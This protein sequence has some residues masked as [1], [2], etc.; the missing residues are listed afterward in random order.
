MY[1]GAGYKLF[2]KLYL[3]GSYNYYFNNFASQDSILS[4]TNYDNSWEVAFGADYRICKYIGISAG[5]EYGNQGITSSSNSTFNPVLDSFVLGGGIEIYP[6]EKL[7]ITAAGMWCKYFDADY[8]LSGIPT[9]LS[10]KI[11]MCSIGITYKPF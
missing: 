11:T 4:E 3:S 6:N 5:F 8:A 7:T 9:E 1:L 10:K 2:D